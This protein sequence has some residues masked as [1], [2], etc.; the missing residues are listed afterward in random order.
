MGEQGE[1]RKFLISDLPVC[2]YTITPLI[3]VPEVIRY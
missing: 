1:E 2:G 3:L